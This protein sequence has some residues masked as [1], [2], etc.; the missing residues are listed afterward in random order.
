[1]SPETSDEDDREEQKDRD[2][3]K[4]PSGGSYQTC[5]GC[6]CPH[7]MG[8]K[9]CSF[10]GAKLTNRVTLSEKTRRKV[11]TARWR[12]KLGSKNKGPA[13]VAKK[14]ARGLL[15]IFLGLLLCFAGIWLAA[16]GGV[17]Q[18][19][20]NMIIGV[21]LAGYGGYAVYKTIKQ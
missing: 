19:F 3:A 15:V 13:S 9:T 11:E 21:L 7:D 5:P 14:A 4:S 8:V 17:S 16:M 20:T 2:P 6:G 18:S 1:M 12:Y 10:C